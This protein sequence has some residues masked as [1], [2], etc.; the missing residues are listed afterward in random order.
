VSLNARWLGQP[1]APLFSTG[2]EKLETFLRASGATLFAGL[3]TC[4]AMVLRLATESGLTLGVGTKS[5]AQGGAA[6]LTEIGAE[7]SG[8]DRSRGVCGR[9]GVQE[10]RGVSDFTGSDVLERLKSLENG[11]RATQRT[12]PFATSADTLRLVTADEVAILGAGQFA[13][14]FNCPSCKAVLRHHVSQRGTPYFCHIGARGDCMSGFESPAHLCIKKGLES[15]GLVTE[16]TD[17]LTGLR[18]D[19]FDEKSKQAVE[20]VCTGIGRYL[21]RLEKIRAAGV[22]MNW[23]FDSAAKGL[24]TK[25]GEERIV[26][27]SRTGGTIVT[28]GF[29]RPKVYELLAAI[30][31]DHLFMFYRG[32]IWRAVAID[33]W[34]LLD[35]SHPFNVAAT[36]DGG[37]KHLMVTM[38]ATN[39]HVVAKKKDGRKTWF[40]QK[41][42]YRGDFAMTW[43]SER[44]YMQ[45][46]VS[47]LIRDLQAAALPRRAVRVGPQSKSDPADPRHL[48]ADDI[49]RKVTEKHAISVAEVAL[50]RRVVEKTRA[51][52]PSV[53]S[54]LSSTIPKPMVVDATAFTV[55]LGRKIVTSRWMPSHKSVSNINKMLDEAA[56]GRRCGCGST[57]FATRRVGNALYDVCSSCGKGK[58]L[59]GEIK[60]RVLLRRR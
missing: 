24:S 11:D 53:E 2:L 27:P 30:P 25:F 48:S 8:A 21:P 5:D 54:S 31:L 44:D 39:S 10:G 41:F 13:L 6:G 23:I 38:K 15:I 19:A 20:V 3:L 57:V 7:A 1:G 9:G 49:V 47:R 32:L 52:S 16:Y 4:S 18:Y 45:E 26:D 29:F 40:E 55:G 58:R 37:I 42:R 56:G 33:R 28:E 17:K 60:S 22:Y 12:N 43:R 46:E 50:L 14:G 59:P 36:S 51:D 34:Q 35:D